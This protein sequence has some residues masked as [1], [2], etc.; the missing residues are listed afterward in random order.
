MGELPNHNADLILVMNR[1]K[2][3]G[4]ERRKEEGKQERREEEEGRKP[5]DKEQYKQRF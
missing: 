1:K 3:R 5:Q 2:G 4:R